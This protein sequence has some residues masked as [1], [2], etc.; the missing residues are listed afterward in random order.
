MRLAR[1]VSLDHLAVAKHAWECKEV[2]A[3]RL[4][5]LRRRVLRLNIFYHRRFV[6]YHL[7]LNVSFWRRL[8]RLGSSR[9]RRHGKILSEPSVTVSDCSVQ[10]LCVRRA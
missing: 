4:I 3:A 7:R 6:R 2:K 9:L 5:R 10:R 8:I 1:A